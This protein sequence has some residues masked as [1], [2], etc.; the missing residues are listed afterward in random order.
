MKMKM[1][2]KNKNKKIYKTNKL[3]INIRN[4]WPY[5]KN[6]FTLFGIQITNDEYRFV[7]MITILNITF[8]IEYLTNKGLKEE[9]KLQKAMHKRRLK[10]KS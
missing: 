6:I 7:F 8:Y 3:K 9:L 1:K 2:N 10:K 5:F 4:D